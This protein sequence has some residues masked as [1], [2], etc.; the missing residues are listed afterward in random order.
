M[1][2]SA[3]SVVQAQ[4]DAYNLHDIEAFTATY[5]EDSYYTR[6]DSGEVVIAGRADVRKA[7]GDLFVANPN[8]HV[9]VTNRIALGRYVIDR[10]VITGREGQPTGNVVAIYEVVDGLI[11]RVWSTRG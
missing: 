6:L 9:E 2:E 11:R 10:E 4:V 3:E 8:V 1:V 5:A 7:F